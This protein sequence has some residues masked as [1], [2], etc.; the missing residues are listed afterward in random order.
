M[1]INRM[2]QNAFIDY[3]R[4]IAQAGPVFCLHVFKIDQQP[5]GFKEAE[6]LADILREFPV[7]R[8]SNPAP[9]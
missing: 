5:S 3:L 6:P 7:D 2:V 9:S 1:F 4:I 8:D